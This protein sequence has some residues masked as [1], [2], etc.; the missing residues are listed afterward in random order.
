MWQDF[1]LG[2][3]GYIFLVALIPQVVRG[4][5]VEKGL[6]TK[7]TALMTGIGMWIISFAHFTLGLLFTGVSEFL[8][9]AMWFVLYY[10]AIKYKEVRKEW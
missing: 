2:I 7:S 10:Q 9:G 6:V 8:L 4:F 5:E 3:V 1:V